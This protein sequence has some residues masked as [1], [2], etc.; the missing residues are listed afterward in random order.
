MKPRN[1]PLRRG[2]AVTVALLTAAI[3]APGPVA[4]ADPAKPAAPRHSDSTVDLTGMPA[5]RH[6]VTLITGDKVTVAPVG[7]RYRVDIAPVSRQD[8]TRPSFLTR[9]APDSLYVYPADALPAVDSG[10]VDRAL[11]DVEYLVKNGYADDA[12]KQLPVIV[13][14]PAGRQAA[15]VRSAADALP[16]SAPTRQLDS[17]HGAALNVAKDQT[18][19]FWASIAGHATPAGGSAVRPSLDA[20]LSKVW[21]D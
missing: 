3:L 4:Q 1:L 19:Q 16:A 11:F 12:A 20:G 15:A 13:Q 10:L 14:Y 8:G 9:I 5:G 6:T 2:P 21:L 7:G 17:I 18:D